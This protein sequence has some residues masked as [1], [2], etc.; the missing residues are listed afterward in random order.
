MDSE[1]DNLLDV[2][3]N[4]YLVRNYDRIRVAPP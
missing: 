4:V 1:G 2:T 3:V